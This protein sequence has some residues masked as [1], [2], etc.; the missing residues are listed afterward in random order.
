[1]KQ[2]KGA[3]SPIVTTT[4]NQFFRA[5]FPVRAQHTLRLN[6]LSDAFIIIAE[7]QVIGGT[8]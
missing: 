1:M 4:F 8:V 6:G 2:E 7:P 5:L 3:Q